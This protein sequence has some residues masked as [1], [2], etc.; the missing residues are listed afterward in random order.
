MEYP[1]E[2]TNKYICFSKNSIFIIPNDANFQESFYLDEKT[3][4]NSS[5]SNS[6]T[7]N[8]S[9]ESLKFMSVLTEN[10]RNRIK[11][12]ISNSKVKILKKLGIKQ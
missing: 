6:K 11:K 12:T 3:E 7:N 2:F 8:T 1:S 9:F 5:F 4:K 10:W